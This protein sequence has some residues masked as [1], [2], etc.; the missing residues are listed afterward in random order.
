MSN[1]SEKLGPVIR[2]TITLCRDCVCQPHDK[3][4]KRGLICLELASEKKKAYLG[5]G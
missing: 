4:R 1:N 5:G 2:K 3:F